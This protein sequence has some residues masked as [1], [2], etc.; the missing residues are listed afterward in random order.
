MNKFVLI[1]CLCALLSACKHDKPAP[2]PAPPPAQVPPVPAPQPGSL[3]F[4]AASYSVAEAAGT[5][6]VTITR[7]GG[8]DGDVSA[9]LAV[10]VAPN[11]DLA[12]EEGAD[13][14]A[15]VDRQIIFPAG[16]STP[17]SL[18]FAITDDVEAELDET[19]SLE[20][21]APSGGATLGAQTVSVLTI[22][23]D[24]YDPA[25]YRMGF[26]VSGLRGT[27]LV[28]TNNLGDSLTIDA[29]GS[30]EFANRIQRGTSVVVSISTQP[31]NPSQPCKSLVRI[32]GVMPARDLLGAPILCLTAG[33]L[34]TSFG[35]GGKLTTDFSGPAAAVTP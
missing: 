18:T 25:G 7:V 8:S 16:D 19:I 29:N 11:D 14:T 27:G 22:L 4:D 35:T 1:A 12:A 23:D 32:S 31:T 34:D 33:R 13:Y 21:S 2:P 3:Q 28:L 20:L 5:F 15:P 30:A 9:L 24:D 10:V 6:S 26:N 17:R